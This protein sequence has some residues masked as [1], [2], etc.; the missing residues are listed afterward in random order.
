MP[1]SHEL[2]GFMSPPLAGGIL[3]F[4]SESGTNQHELETRKSFQAG[5]FQSRRDK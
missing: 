3:N 1:T 5:S 2:F 4:S